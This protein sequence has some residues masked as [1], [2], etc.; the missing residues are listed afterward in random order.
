VKRFTR[1]ER[2]SRAE[3]LADE[4]PR[5]CDETMTA[6]PTFSESP[7]RIGNLEKEDFLKIP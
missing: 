3:Q 2:S 6:V 5:S 1:I 4:A 7:S